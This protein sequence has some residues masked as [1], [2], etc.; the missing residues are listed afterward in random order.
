IPMS[1]LSSQPLVDVD[2][3]VVL[4]ATDQCGVVADQ[5]QATVN[6]RNMGKGRI[7]A[8][9]QVLQ[10]T[11]TGPFGLGGAGGP[12]GGFPGGGVIIVLP[13]GGAAGGG[14]GGQAIP[15]FGGAGGAQA[16]AGAI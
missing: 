5:Q 8:S 10:Y 14:G 12:G 11:N 15:G 9:A 2:S 7:T 3:P 1:Q 13:G 6:L 16:G 4:L